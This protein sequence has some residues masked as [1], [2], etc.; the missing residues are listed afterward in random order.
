MCE[1]VTTD[2]YD[3][4]C[5]DVGLAQKTKP[6]AGLVAGEQQSRRC[7]LLCAQFCNIKGIQEENNV[8][9]HMHDH[10]AFIR[11]DDHE[12]AA[13]RSNAFQQNS[14]KAVKSCDHMDIFDK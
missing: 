12:A 7:S 3:V 9:I 8:Y 4:L 6:Q 14:T 10:A 2:V 11:M 13:M 1:F 5:L